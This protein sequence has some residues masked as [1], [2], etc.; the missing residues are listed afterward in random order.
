MN[1]DRPALV[2]GLLLAAVEVGAMTLKPPALESNVLA[3]DGKV[4]FCQPDKSFTVLD[5]GTGAVL[6]RDTD[7]DCQGG[8]QPTGEGPL[9]STHWSWYR[10]IDV[11]DSIARGRMIVRWEMGGAEE[12]PCRSSRVIED[13]LV[14]ARSQDFVVE[15]RSLADNRVRWTY[16]AP[17]A[18]MDIVP[19]QGRLLL[20]SGDYRLARDVSIVD[21]R[22]GRPLFREAIVQ[23]APFAV[24][25]FDGQRVVLAARPP[26]GSACAGAIVR[27]LTPA[28]DRMIAQDA[29]GEDDRPRS[30]PT[31]RLHL[32][33]NGSETSLRFQGGRWIEGIV[34]RGTTWWV[35][36][37]DGVGLAAVHELKGLLVLERRTRKVASLECLEAASG[38][39]LWTYVYNPYRYPSREWDGARAKPPKGTVPG[40]DLRPPE[41][42]DGRRPHP[43]EQARY[44]G[45]L[46]FDPTPMRAVEPQPTP[47]P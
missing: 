29:C 12:A 6:V 11:D 27:T 44:P 8:L 9:L 21:L 17:G 46:V 22:T 26:E 14:C 40:G 25:S 2:L 24:R 7:A 41:A 47:L 20:Q 18:V 32:G 30:T 35:Y 5:L 16:E 31:P 23:D 36:A 37:R 19:K 38:R 43:L 13:R 34:K 28:G 1:L 3:A 42:E 15:S 4:F 39:P 10:M 33:W 45:R